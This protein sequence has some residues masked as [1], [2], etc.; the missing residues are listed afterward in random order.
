MNSIRRFLLT[1]LI[2]GAALTLLVAGLSVYLVL[3][4]SL[5]R[6]FDRSLDDALRGLASLMFQVEDDVRFEFSDQ[7]MPEYSRES[8]PEYFELVRDDG[9]VL[10]RSDSLRG[11]ALVDGASRAGQSAAHWSAPLPDGRSGRY[12]GRWIDVHH[13]YPE[14]GPGRPTAARVHIVIARGREVLVEAER[15]ALGACVL[16]ALILTLALCVVAWFA[17]AR[18][19]APARRVAST[20]AQVDLAALP[21]ELDFGALPSELAPVGE[22]ASA[23]VRRVDAALER[24]RRTS[25]DIAHELRT[26]ASELLAVCEVALRSGHDPAQLREALSRSRDIA[27]RMGASLATLLE[28]SR[29]EMAREELPHAP[30]DL[31]AVLTE[32]R[33]ALRPVERERELHVDSQTPEPCEVRAAPEALRIVVS[34]LIANAVHYSPRGSRVSI[35]LEHDGP[36]WRLCV[37]NPAPELTGEDLRSMSQPFWRKD[38]ARSDGAHAGL[39]LAL[40]STLAKAARLELCF[41][42]EAGELC[43]SIGS[44]RG[45]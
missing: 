18:G 34:N 33:R 24:E 36:R 14:E 10:E 8:S 31:R 9:A 6:Q 13:V 41:E 27:W 45:S 43:A 42:L 17:V 44:V 2:G 23:L 11:A 35:R 37:R 19:L 28:L 40:S 1:R 25:A 29:L 38:H 5:E 12:V 3:E 4:R 30:C 22:K 21:R 32:V 16:V 7:L 20:L 15:R 39:G 26:P